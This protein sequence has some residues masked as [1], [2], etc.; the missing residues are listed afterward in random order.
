MFDG[1]WIYSDTNSYKFSVNDLQS[2][3]KS[4]SQKIYLASFWTL[5]AFA[6]IPTCLFLLTVSFENEI[7]QAPCGF[8]FFHWS[9]GG[10]LRLC[11]E[12][13]K[14]AW[15]PTLPSHLQ[16]NVVE[17]PG[18][19]LRAFWMVPPAFSSEASRSADTN[20]FPSEAAGSENL[21]S[22]RWMPTLIGRF[23]KATSLLPSSL[24]SCT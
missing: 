21:P 3:L 19:A 20:R 14:S 4:W 22:S 12:L 15:A 17:S 13:L 24:L 18:A 8:S 16:R 2:K 1:F 11:G 10:T 7:L 9:K 23:P 6:S 5:G